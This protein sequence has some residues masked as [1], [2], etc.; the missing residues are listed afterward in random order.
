MEREQ[1]SDIKESQLLDHYQLR[2]LLFEANNIWRDTGTMFRSVKAR[3]EMLVE[4]FF[5]KNFIHR[6]VIPALDS[7]RVHQTLSEVCLK[8]DVSVGIR[9]AF[10]D[11]RLAGAPWIMQNSSETSE[12]FLDKTLSKYNEWIRDKNGTGKPEALIIMENPKNLGEPDLAKNSFVFRIALIPSE[13]RCILEGC[14]WTDQ[15]RDLEETLVIDGK[16]IE[17][18][19]YDVNRNFRGALFFD[20]SPEKIVPKDFHW[21]EKYLE[22]AEHIYLYKWIYRT[23]W[24]V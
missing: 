8:K 18:P 14:P 20:I 5:P 7:E 3:Q 17:N 22:K 16:R 15:T 9:T 24:L 6:H 12:E 4:K 2:P 23:F 21:E 19:H 13:S 10:A 1:R 11:S